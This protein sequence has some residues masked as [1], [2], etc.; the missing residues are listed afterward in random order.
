MDDHEIGFANR[1]YGGGRRLGM[2][3]HLAATNRFG[4]V[5]GN[6]LAAIGLRTRRVGL[7]ARAD[8]FLSPHGA[9]SRL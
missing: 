6:R 5:A 3:L 7:N 8:A 1:G 9:A 4:P 2:P